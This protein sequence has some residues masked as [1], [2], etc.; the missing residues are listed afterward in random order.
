[1]PE[2]ER[3]YRVWGYPYVPRLAILGMLILLVVTFIN[4][5]EASMLGVFVI[6][7]GNGFYD[8]FMEKV[9]YE[10][11]VALP[12]VKSA[13]AKTDVTTVAKKPRKKAAPKA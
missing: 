7:I 8:V 9:A 6:L 5:F 3:P 4:S 11:A 1:M 12:L 10:P 2:A 13:K